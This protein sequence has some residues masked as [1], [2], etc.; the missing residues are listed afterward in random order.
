MNDKE[1]LSYDAI[2]FADVGK[3][4]DAE[5]RRL[6]MF[7]RMGGGVIYSAG[8]EVWKNRELHNNFLFEKGRGLLPGPFSTIPMEGQFLFDTQP[9]D[10]KQPPL[11]A[12]EDEKD[13][14]SLNSSRFQKY[15]VIELPSDSSARSVVSFLHEEKPLEKGAMRPA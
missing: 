14:I 5:V 9:G 10:F 8:P 13:K 3:V 12:F 4:G 15:V 11:N 1:L 7:L 2:F 6:K